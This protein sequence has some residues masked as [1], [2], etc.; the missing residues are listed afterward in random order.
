MINLLENLF[1][2]KEILNRLTEISLNYVL[3]LLEEKR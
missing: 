3:G 2:G 1:R